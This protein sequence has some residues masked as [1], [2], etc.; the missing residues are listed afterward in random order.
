MN[1]FPFDPICEL[2]LSTPEERTLEELQEYDQDWP[3]A[4]PFL[5][6]DFITSREVN[7]LYT[8]K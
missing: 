3:T 8:G 2:F 4:A 6:Q 7:N 1:S 5:F